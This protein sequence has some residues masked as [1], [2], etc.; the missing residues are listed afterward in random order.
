MN[1]E[2][3]DLTVKSFDDINLHYKKDLIDN[4]KAIILISHGLAEHCGRY[5][6]TSKKLNSFGYSVYRYDLRGHGLSDGRRGFIKKVD[7]LFEDANTF[8]N[9]IKS[10]N[11]GKP[12]FMLGHSLG[13][14]ILAGFGCKYKDK[15][16]GMIFCSSLICD[17]FGYTDVEEEN[18]DPYTLIPECNVHDLTHDLEAIYSYE[19]DGLVLEYITLGM[20]NALN[21]SCSTIENIIPDFK[22]P[23][24]I[25]HSSSDSIVS[26]ED[27][28]YLFNNI[29]SNDK[30]FMLIN[31]LYHKL[32]DE[33]MKDE[34]LLKISSWMDLRIEK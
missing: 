10:E 29:T 4:P 12:I 22:Y 31:G 16:N 6:Y 18:P 11:P 14:H 27:S 3:I 20:Y 21:E 26:P 34:I 15:V 8:V 30:E 17:N 33:I 7:D 32:L 24:L 2:S 28:K 5:D 9:L 23:S 25:I 13:G 1:F 19:N